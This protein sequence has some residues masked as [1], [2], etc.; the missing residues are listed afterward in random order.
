MARLYSLLLSTALVLA[1]LV[2]LPTHVVEAARPTA[3][4]QAKP[5][6]V[7]V[8]MKERTDD[9]LQTLRTLKFSTRE[10]R[11]QAFKDGLESHAT[12]TQHDLFALLEQSGSTYTRSESFWL[13]NQ[14]FIQGATPALISKIAKLSSVQSVAPEEIFPHVFPTLATGATTTA[15]VTPQWGVSKIRAPEVW[16]TGN[17]GKGVVIGVIDTGVRHTHKDIAGNFRQSFGWFDPEKKIATPYDTTGHGTHVVGTIAG[18]N[19]IGVAPGA[20]WIMCKGCRANGCYA[21]ELLACFQFMACPTTPDGRTKDCSK[22]PDIVNNSWGAGQGVSTFDAVIATW[23]ANQI[24]PVFAGGNAGPSCKTIT[25][26]GDKANVITVGATDSNDALA[27]F[28]SK[29]PSVV[30]GIRKPDVL[31]PGATIRSAC[32]TGDR[33]YCVKSGTSMA[34]PHVTG[35]IALY[36]VRYPPPAPKSTTVR[37]TENDAPYAD[38]VEALRATAQT[39]V[40]TIS[41]GYTCGSTSDKVFPNNQ[42]GYGRLDAVK[43]LAFRPKYARV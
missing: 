28:S 27:S 10:K 4:K 5:M 16:A 24:I 26:P 13:T 42:F 43:L 3:K 29:G 37:L 32:F 41:S 20:T 18:A 12:R 15:S 25:S 40:L 39:S 8:T 6:N 30:G 11:S 38:V 34:A 33:D 36:F 9:V 17:T 21:S 14:V 31:A 1:S 35:M 22:Q 2:S 7:I 23:H 19:G